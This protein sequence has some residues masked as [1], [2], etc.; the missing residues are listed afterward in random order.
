MVELDQIFKDLDIRDRIQQ[1][2]SS[3]NK[4]KYAEK[5]LSSKF[6]WIEFF[7]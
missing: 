5:N 2:V 7:W 4:A 6:N 1:T 3:F